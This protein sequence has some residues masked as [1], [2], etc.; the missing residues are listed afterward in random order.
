MNEM[1]ARERYNRFQ[2]LLSLTNENVI[3]RKI[4]SAYANGDIVTVEEALSRMVVYLCT[5]WSEQQRRMFELVQATAG[6]LKV[7]AE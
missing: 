2:E 7:P 4:V 5:D 3:V 6:V 1:I